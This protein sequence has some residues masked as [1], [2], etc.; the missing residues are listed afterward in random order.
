[1]RYLNIGRV[2]A[3]R[4]RAQAEIDAGN[5]P[6]CQYALAIDGE[7]VLAETLGRAE[8]SNRYCMFSSTKPIVASLVWQLIG[9]GLLELAKPLATW[10]PEFARNGKEEVTLEHLLLFTCGFPFAEVDWD[11]IDDRE[12]RAAQMESWTLEWRPG[13]RYGYHGLS[14]HWAL[15]ELI[16]RVTDQ[17]YRVALR[18]RVLDPLGLARLE[19]GTP[20]DHQHDVLPMESIGQPPSLEEVAK[21]LG[22][23][24]STLPSGAIIDLT[25]FNAPAVRAVGVPG[26]GAIS[27]AA[28]LALFYQALLHNPRALW[29][30]DVLQDAT[31][32]VRNRLPGLGI[33]SAERTIGL[34]IAGEGVGRVLRTSMGAGSPRTFGHGG[35]GG[36]QAWADPETGLSFAF[37]TNGD[38]LDSEHQLRRCAELNRNAV[39]CLAL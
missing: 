27:D 24:P 13:T 17:D 11:T 19:L 31:G 8:P 6:S 14:A 34:E 26:G 12:S 3:L 9:E 33:D 20:V 21:F 10:W 2:E 18:E 23:E 5:I 36:Q 16:M 28:S 4:R 30:H 1:M 22:Y 25:R 7:V 38:H 32:N 15:T 35:A 39:E 29:D 37:L